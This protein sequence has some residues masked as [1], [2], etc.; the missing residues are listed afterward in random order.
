MLKLGS[1]YLTP[2]PFRAALSARCLAAFLVGTMTEALPGGRH[3]GSPAPPAALPAVFF[4]LS[5]RQQGSRAPPATA[6]AQFQI[7]GA[8]GAETKVIISAISC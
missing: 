6:F 5:E 4:P 3:G 8:N 1:A 2:P 7:E